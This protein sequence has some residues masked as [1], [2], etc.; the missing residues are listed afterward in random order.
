MP[1]DRTPAAH[2]YLHDVIEELK[3]SGFIADA[4]RGSGQDA[5]VAG[6][7]TAA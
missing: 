4:L 2:A 5:T 1:H 7:D 3:S 6:P